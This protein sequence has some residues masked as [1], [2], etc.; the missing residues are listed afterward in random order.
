MNRFSIKLLIICVISMIN[1]SAIMASKEKTPA[2][3][4]TSKKQPKPTPSGTKSQPAPTSIIKPGSMPIITRETKN[5]LTPELQAE[6]QKSSLSILKPTAE[7]LPVLYQS[8]PDGSLLFPKNP[9]IASQ[10]NTMIGT[11]K[12]NPE[13]I[14]FFRKIHINSLN[15]LYSYLMKIYTNFNLINPGFIQKTDVPTGDEAAYLVDEA[16]YATNIKK[17]IM[18]HFI[19]IIQAQFG[20]SIVSYSPATPPDMAVTLGKMFVHN[21]YGIDL[22][23]FALPQT[24]PKIIATQ[25]PYIKFLQQYIQFFQTYTDCLSKIDATTGVNQYF[26][27]AQSIKKMLEPNQIPTQTLTMN[28][29][30]FFYDTESMRS[31]QFI[32]FVAG[33][34]QKNS[35]LIPWA[36]I[37]VNAA[38]KNTASNGHPVAFFTDALDKKTPNQNQAQHLYL[39]V[40]TGPA[41]FQQELL[42]QPGWLN[43]QDGC[44]RIL[45]A[46]LGDFSALVGMG[47][48]D[49]ETETIIQKTLPQQ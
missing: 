30:M 38:V 41:L 31:I 28:P 3:P 36:S 27:I 29:N 1:Y 21:D 40:E 8:Y 5:D 15:Q 13:L 20:A 24:D 4:K 16:T 9:D 37:V 10:F 17:L 26:T 42:A 47:I 25:T 14:E 39:L 6:A 43:A 44:I 18:N 33:T 34:I 2:A 7:Q 46:C 23:P 49:N 32:P 11:I 12:K 45:R 35:P 48:L 22:T 19:N